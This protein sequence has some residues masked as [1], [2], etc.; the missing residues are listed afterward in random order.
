MNCDGDSWDH[1][2]SLALEIAD[3]SNCDGNSKTFSPSILITTISIAIII[4]ILLMV[5]FIITILTII[6]T[7]II[8][9]LI[10]LPHAWEQVYEI[11]RPLGVKMV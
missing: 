3:N 2:V 6:T 10:I 7:F 8:T 1:V 4:T 9:R 11:G 5:N